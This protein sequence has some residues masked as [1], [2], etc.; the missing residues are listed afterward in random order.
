MFLIFNKT[1]IFVFLLFLERDMY[2][3]AIAS[4]HINQINY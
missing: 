3:A 1:Y 4:C 2:I